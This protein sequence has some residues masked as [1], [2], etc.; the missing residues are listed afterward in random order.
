[1][2]SWLSSALRITLPRASTDLQELTQEMGY[3]KTQ[4]QKGV[5]SYNESQVPL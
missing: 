1:M 2:T 5:Q 3:R 4:P